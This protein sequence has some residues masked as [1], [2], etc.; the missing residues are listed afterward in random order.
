MHKAKLRARVLGSP[1]GQ[2]DSAIAAT[3]CHADSWLEAHVSG[4]LAHVHFND[5]KT[6]RFHVS[7]DGVGGGISRCPC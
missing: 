1:F 6:I 7:R 5:P 2:C 3:Q 4:D